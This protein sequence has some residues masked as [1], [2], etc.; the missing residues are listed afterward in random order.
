MVVIRTG[1]RVHLGGLACAFSLSL[2]LSLGLPPPTHCLTQFKY[3]HTRYM[4]TRGMRH[5]CY[6]CYALV[7]KGEGGEE[8]LL[9]APG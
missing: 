9:C 8:A 1:Q 5:Q 2:S 3:I 7:Q 6:Q 4:C